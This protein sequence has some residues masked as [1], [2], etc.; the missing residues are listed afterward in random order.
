MRRFTLAWIVAWVG[1]GLLIY[2]A[3]WIPGRTQERL[4][5]LVLLGFYLFTLPTSLV[6]FLIPSTWT[7]VV[8]FVAGYQWPLLIYYRQRNRRRLGS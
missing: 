3:A 5:D 1:A 6:S 8:W 4:L 7:M 2:A